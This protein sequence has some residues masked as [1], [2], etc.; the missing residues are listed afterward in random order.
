MFRVLLTLCSYSFRYEKV[1]HVIVAKWN[2]WMM[3][4]HYC[5]AKHVNDEFSLLQ[6]ETREYWILI[7]GKYKTLLLICHCCSDQPVWEWSC[8]NTKTPM[9]D[10][11]KVQLHKYWRPQYSCRRITLRVIKRPCSVLMRNPHYAKRSIFIWI[12][13]LW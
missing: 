5:K 7:V 8:W 1:S 4:F 13:D 6:S 10:R 2:T 9:I 12:W 11:K 3:N